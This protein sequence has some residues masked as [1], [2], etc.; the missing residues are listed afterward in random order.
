M[1]P[2]S[3]NV[4][5]FYDG[6]C[7]LCTRE[8]GMLR[9]WDKKNK[10]RFT[11][12]MDPQFNASQ[13]GLT[14]DDFMS[15]IR[16]RMPDGRIIVGMEVFRQ[17]YSSVGYGWLVAPTRLPI[18]KQICDLGYCIFAKKRLWLT[19]RCKDSQCKI[20]LKKKSAEPES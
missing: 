13:F 3:W 10:I 11:D 6:E 9:R 1:Q 19:G 5:V 12:I 2:E 7:P 20:D 18:I 15:Q 17:L 14:H 4:E 8:I 16:G